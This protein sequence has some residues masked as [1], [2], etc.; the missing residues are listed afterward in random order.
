MA[1]V[2]G[3]GSRVLLADDVGMGKTIQAGLIIKELQARG[4]AD[5][6]L[7][8]TPSG[9]RDQWR[10]ELADR[11]AIAADVVD[12]R[13]IRRRC[14][15]VPVGLNPWITTP[16]AIA[17]ID[18][19]KRPEV[20]Q[21]VRACWWDVVVLD[22]A[23]GAGRDSDRF[24]SASALAARAAYVVLLTATPHNG[25]PRAFAALCD[26]G[27]LD[28]PL[29]VFRRTRAAVSLGAGRRV[30]RLQVRASA[31]ESRMHALLADFTR[32][33]R[34]E[35]GSSDAWLALSVL[36]KRAFSSARS[37]E[38]TVRRRL[39]TLGPEAAGGLRQMPLPLTDPGGEFDAA[40]E[41]P[42][43]LASLAL[44]DSGRER[45]LLGA[46][47]DAAQ[48][49][50]AGETKLLAAAAAAEACRGADR[51]LHRIPRHLVAS[52]RGAWAAGADAARRP[53]AR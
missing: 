46:L 17:S 30:R 7:I 10:L 27:A 23:H 26:I 12:F 50:S 22:E 47:R 13:E 1:V 8:V 25:D 16:I 45:R 44:A 11:F 31:A 43:C 35:H 38:L 18:Y 9:L 14:L 51:D 6:I 20:L 2:R 33:V 41:S 40:D 42:D 37:L 53:D 28:D 15:T 21:S 49:A 39:D 24:V 52:P 32:A 34:S 36:H 3:L 19:V 29:L 5:R 4:Q 48:R